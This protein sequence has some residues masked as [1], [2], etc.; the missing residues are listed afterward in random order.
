MQLGL[1]L[2]LIGALAAQLA[3]AGG[4]PNQQ[5]AAGTPRDA[6]VGGVDSDTDGDGILDCAPDALINLHAGWGAIGDPAPTKSGALTNF[7]SEEKSTEDIP[8]VASDFSQHSVGES[9]GVTWVS[10]DRQVL[11]ILEQDPKG[12]WYVA[13]RGVCSDVFVK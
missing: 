5:V 12:Q 8:V 3:I 7:F 13:A 9:G 6:D 4:A 2:L 1:L 10:D 11:A